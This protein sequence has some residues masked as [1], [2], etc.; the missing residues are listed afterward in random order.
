MRTSNLKSLRSD[1]LFLMIATYKEEEQLSQNLPR[2]YPRAAPDISAL[3]TKRGS[4]PGLS[5]TLEIR[6]VAIQAIESRGC[7]IL[8]ASVR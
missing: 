6:R 7:L 5:L 8:S 4:D 1:A 3:H 2:E